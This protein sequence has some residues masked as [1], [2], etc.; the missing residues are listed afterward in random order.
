MGKIHPSSK[1]RATEID[2]IRTECRARRLDTR[3][4]EG[5]SQPVHMLRNISRHDVNPMFIALQLNRLLSG[6]E[7]IISPLNHKKCS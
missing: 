2:Q 6:C 5:T 1:D 3:L 4:S 7:P